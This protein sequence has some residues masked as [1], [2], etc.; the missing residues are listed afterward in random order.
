MAE[1]V[2]KPSYPAEGVLLLTLSRP[3]KRNAFTSQMGD[4]LVTALDAASRDAAVRAVVVTGDPAGGAFCAGADLSGD[5]GFAGGKGVAG[6]LK[7]DTAGEGAKAAQM[8]DELKAGLAHLSGGK[9]VAGEAKRDVAGE[10][11]KAARPKPS[12][13][14]HRD[15][16]GFTSL[17][18][19][20]CTKPVIAAVNGAAVGVGLAFPTACDIRIVA[21]NAKIGFPMAARGLVN[22]SIS[23]YLLPRIVGPGFA[24]ELVFTGRVFVASEAPR[25]APGLFNYILPQEQVL[26]K[27]LELAKEIASNTS[28]M[29]VAMCKSLMDQAWDSTPEEAM[30]NESM[31]LFYV[32]NVKKGDVK[33]GI[34]SF[35]QKRKPKWVHDAWDDLP[36]FLPFAPKID[37][38]PGRLRRERPDGLS[39][40]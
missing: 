12:M 24:K 28:G 30:I 34:S 6:E 17:A 25:F 37:V 2:V 10:G 8:G 26:P 20:R 7:R 9:E 36:D 15:E 35:L 16:G 29:S 19:L 39:R 1:T 32:N 22:E 11:V 14:T 5:N 13:S 23:S 3:S 27:A 31:C 40:L 33:E 21:E 18:A 38:R 4:E